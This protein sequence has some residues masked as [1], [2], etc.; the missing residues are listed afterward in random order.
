MNMFSTD[1]TLDSSE[2]VE[3][4]YAQLSAEFE[5]KL[6]ELDAQKGL[7]IQSE[8]D[9]SQN[10]HSITVKSSANATES[11]VEPTAQDFLRQGRILEYQGHHVS[12][13]YQFQVIS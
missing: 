1:D 11:D 12:L 13:M 3:L 8:D 6:A 2:D 5:Q 4:L 7:N 9:I 10:P